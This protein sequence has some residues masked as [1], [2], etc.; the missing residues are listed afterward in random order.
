MSSTKKSTLRAP[1]NKFWSN[2]SELISR[3]SRTIALTIFFLTTSPAFAWNDCGHMAI[4]AIAYPHLTAATKQRVDT[5]LQLNP[6]YKDWIRGVEPDDRQR[7]AFMKAATWA[8]SIKR[9]SDYDSKPEHGATPIRNIGYGDTQQH[10]QWHYINLPFSSDHAP[11]PSATAPNL[12]TQIAALRYALQTKG[13]NAATQSYSLAWLL[14]LVG[15]AHQPL[16]ATSRFSHDFPRGD[17]G[18]NA[19]ILCEHTCNQN[20][21]EYWDR[22]L[23]TTRKPRSIVRMAAA[24]PAADPQRA[25]IL[26]ETVWLQE[27]AGISHQYVYAA[28]VGNAADSIVLS[29]SYKLAARDIAQKQAA[30][31]GARLAN[32]L[33]KL[34][35][36]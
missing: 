6:N 7:I 11:L 15:D 17:Q 22:V 16:H 21:H 34:F 20:L 18:G 28:P 1:T 10:R 23:G 13:S 9:D 26:D 5:L 25:A 14:H 19:V 35:S 32:L 29:K 30:V 2:Q 36:Q 31:A 12:K 24:Y 8:D 4:A 3:L 27:S 33:N